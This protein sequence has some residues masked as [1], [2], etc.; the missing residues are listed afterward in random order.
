MKTRLCRGWRG[1]GALAFWMTAFVERLFEGWRVYGRHGGVEVDASMAPL[2]VGRLVC[3]RKFSIVLVCY[4]LLC[5]EGGDY[6]AGWG[7]G[8]GCCLMRRG[9]LWGTQVGLWNGRWEL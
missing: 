2:F 9:F 7:V 4:R 3:S 5:W 8:K 6:R 1:R